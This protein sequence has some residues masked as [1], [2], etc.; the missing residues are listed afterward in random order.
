MLPLVIEDQSRLDMIAAEAKAGR[1]I[2]VDLINQRVNTATGEQLADFE[3]EE[4]RKHCLLNGLDDIGLTMQMGDK[5]TEFEKG[6]SLNTP[7]LDGS[8]YLNRGRRGGPVK[9][10]AAPVPQTRRGGQLEEPLAW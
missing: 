10:E 5:I 8:G 9:V 2:E 1:E 3:V 4:F 6:R 7:W